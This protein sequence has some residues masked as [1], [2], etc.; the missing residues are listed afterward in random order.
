MSISLIWS[1][2]YLINVYFLFN[3]QGPDIHRIDL[4][5]RSRVKKMRSRESVDDFT[6]V[7][8]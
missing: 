7:I 2:S 4:D 3:K 5:L 6:Y 8:R 1:I